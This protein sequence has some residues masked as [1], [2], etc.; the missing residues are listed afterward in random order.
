MKLLFSLKNC[1]KKI[2]NFCLFKWLK[3]MTTWYLIK[4]ILKYKH[5]QVNYLWKLIKVIDL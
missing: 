1:T 3:A 5:P 2:K 4:Y